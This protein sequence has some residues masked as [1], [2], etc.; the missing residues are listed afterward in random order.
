MTNMVFHNLR[1]VVL[2]LAAFALGA[3]AGTPMQG[4]T[5]PVLPS[6]QT[7]L[8]RSGPHTDIVTC[9][10]VRVSGLSVAVLPG[11]HT[12]EMNLTDRPD[13]DGYF[14]AY[15]FYSMGTGS[16]SFTAEAGHKYTVYVNAAPAPATEEEVGT[17]YTWAGYIEDETT[18]KRLA[19]T[20]R[21]PLG[22]EPRGYPGGAPAMHY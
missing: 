11:E 16:V 22:V 12:I 7:A 10:G 21:L 2:G 13:T 18:H 20:D 19:R 9:D 1:I 3:C 4:Y 14:G 6:D 5:G 8:V 15:F 17:G